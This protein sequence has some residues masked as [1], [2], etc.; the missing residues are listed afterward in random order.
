M[1]IL[2]KQQ[3]CMINK[4]D[5]RRVLRLIRALIDFNKYLPLHGSTIITII[6]DEFDLSGAYQAGEP[7]AYRS[8]ICNKQLM[9]TYESSM[10]D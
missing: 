6:R 7:H 2:H 3:L 8:S 1:H 5:H 10:K 4:V 9:H